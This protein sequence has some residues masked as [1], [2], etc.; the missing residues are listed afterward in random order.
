MHSTVSTH[1]INE[2][3]LNGAMVGG[4]FVANVRGCRRRRAVHK[5]GQKTQEAKMEIPGGGS[6]T[7]LVQASM[8]CS[9][10]SI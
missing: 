4:D 5:E 6:G 3:T 7:A 2:C 8:C 1:A 9:C 10:S